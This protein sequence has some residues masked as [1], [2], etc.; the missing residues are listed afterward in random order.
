MTKPQVSYTCKIS[1]VVLVL[2]I[3]GC[4][5]LPRGRVGRI[6]YVARENN[7]SGVYIMDASG[8][9]SELLTGENEIPI[10]V[11]ISP[12]GE[13]VAIVSLQG[14]TPELSVSHENGERATIVQGAN[15]AAWSPDETKLIFVVYHADFG[16][17]YAINVDGAGLKNLTNTENWNDANPA[18]SPDG[19]NIAFTSSSIRKNSSCIRDCIGARIYVID[20]NG[21]ECRLL[22]DFPEQVHA[23]GG[24]YLM[25]S[26]TKPTWSPTSDRI[27]FVSNLDG[28]DKLYVI[29]LDGTGLTPLTPEMQYITNPAWSPDGKHIAFQAWSRMA[30]NFNIYTVNSDGSSLLQLTEDPDADSDPAW[31]PDGTWI[32]FLSEKDRSIYVF[33]ADGAGLSKLT[34]DEYEVFDFSWGP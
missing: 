14:Q 4:T 31:S 22:T 6:A 15:D 18:W 27:A 9:K 5:I 29:E 17:I 13:M 16:D 25:V 2:V 8:G 26:A 32:A 23:S 11:S 21:A 33:R 12:S 19:K 3:T 7:V 28:T 24:V 20:S 10:S 30:K 1:G 34:E